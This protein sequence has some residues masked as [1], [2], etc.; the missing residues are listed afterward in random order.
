MSRSAK[1]NLP[2][3]RADLAFFLDVDGTLLPIAETPNAVSPSTS[4]CALLTKLMAASGGAIALISGRSLVEL[5]R[6]FCG[7]HLPAA[8]QHGCERRD[9]RGRITRIEPHVASLNALRNLMY[10]MAGADVRLLLEDK[11]ASLAL[12]YRRAPERGPELMANL[13]QVLNGYPQFG[14]QPGKMVLEVRPIGI[15]KAHAVQAFMAEPQ[16]L[17]RIPVFIGDDLTDEDGFS[18][19]NEL[20]GISIKVGS[21]NSVA[22]YRAADTVD[23]LNWLMACSESTTSHARFSDA[24]S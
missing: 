10:E 16:F 3:P 21:G 23:V 24:Q 9:A 18:M 11:G 14:L 4:V 5:D 22:C 17:R 1:K 6:L 7:L 12:H 20:G 13:Q 8:G 19:V 15:S 2:K